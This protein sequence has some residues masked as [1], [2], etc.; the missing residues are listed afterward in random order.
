M[1]PP[2]WTSLSPL[3]L[4]YSSSLSQSTR[5]E[6][7]VSYRK[8][9]LAIYFTYGNVYFNATLSICPTLSFPS[10]VHKSVPHVCVSKEWYSWLDK[11][12]RGSSALE[13]GF[14]IQDI[15][16]CPGLNAGSS[17]WESQPQAYRRP[18]AIKE[19]EERKKQ[20]AWYLFVCLF[21]G[22][23]RW[24][25]DWRTSLVAQMLKHLSTMWETGFNPWVGKI[26]RR[27]KWQPTPVLLP[28]KSHGQRNLVGY[29]PRGCKESDTTERLHRIQK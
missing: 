19:D 23:G 14:F 8:F 28:G 5:F 20:I 2:S 25:G 13:E 16:E 26:L 3:T 1:S 7:P 29:S 18:Q 4:S 22:F 10:F 17:E 11:K 9:P 6:F 12:A 24:I 15:L 27:R 21:F